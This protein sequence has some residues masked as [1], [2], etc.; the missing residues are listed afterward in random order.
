MRSLNGICILDS[1]D[2][3][4]GVPQLGANLVETFV[5]KESSLERNEI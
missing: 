5:E 4:P 3:L 1:I 2:G